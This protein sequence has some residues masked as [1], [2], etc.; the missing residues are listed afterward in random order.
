LRYDALVSEWLGSGRSP[1]FGAV[2]PR[3][4]LAE[5]LL[6]YLAHAKT[7]YGGEQRS[8]YANMKAAIRP[9][10]NLYAKIPAEEFGP[11]QFRAVRQHLVDANR[12]RTGINAVMKRIV[13]V[14]RWAASEGLTS[15]IIP[16]A[17]AMVPGLRRGKCGVRES[18][19]VCP[20]DPAVVQATLP[21]L[22]AVVRA[23]VELQRLT[24]ARPGEICNL[25]PCDIDRAAGEV[26]EVRLTDHK[27]AH[28]GKART[29]YLGR[30][31]QAVLAPYLI[32]DSTA[33]CFS[34]AEAEQQRRER[35]SANR[36]T[37]LSCGNR[38]GTNRVLKPRRKPSDK[39]TTQAYGKAIAYA[40]ARLNPHPRLSKKPRATLT[41]AEKTELR[42]WNRK[43]RWSPNQLRHLVATELRREFDLDTA[44]TL[45]GHSHVGTTEIYAEKDRRRAIEATKLVG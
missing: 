27:T 4:S 33:Y 43:H 3:L 10:K 24:G 38:V 34:P 6:G 1:T 8:E 28:H 40:C 9:L 42:E 44:K 25:R 29:I 19:P 11:Q 12:T 7:Y 2:N 15:P 20:V 30:R 37:P 5:L 18:T 45:L 14:F 17:L 21:A 32:R 13:R 35:L 39:Y 31:S 26:W 36:K 22:T 41:S 16:Q 23:M